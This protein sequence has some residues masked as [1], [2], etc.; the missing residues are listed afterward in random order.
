MI[1][2]TQ[3]GRI[4]YANAPDALKKMADHVRYIQEQL[5]WTLQN[6]DS[7]NITEINTRDTKISSDTVD[8]SG[9]LVRLNGRNGEVFEVGVDERNGN[10]LFGL[11]GRNG[12]PI[13]YLTA[14]GNLVITNNA[15]IVVDGGTW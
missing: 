12:T 1:F 14:D 10:F 4:D 15:T 7:S 3:L 9:N 2:T 5:E 8:L 13:C 6:L 11:Y